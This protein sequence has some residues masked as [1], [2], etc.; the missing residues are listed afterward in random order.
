MSETRLI[1]SNLAIRPARPED[2]DRIMAIHNTINADMPPIS[3]AQYREYM[4]SQPKEAALERYVAEL[5]GT[6]AGAM[7]IQEDAFAKRAGTAYAF[8]EV[9]APHRERGIGSRLSELVDKRSSALGIKRMY[10]WI[11]EDSPQS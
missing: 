6:I 8:V 7:D 2:D 10:S 5:E 3:V 9:E 11:R 1:P 4:T